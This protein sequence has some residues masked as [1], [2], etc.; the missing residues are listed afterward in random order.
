MADDL[1]TEAY[2][3]KGFQ[4]P[5]VTPL[6]EVKDLAGKV[7]IPDVPRCDACQPTN[8]REVHWRSGVLRL[9]AINELNDE[10]P[11]AV[12]EPASFNAER[13]SFE[14]MW[15]SGAPVVC[16][17]PDSDEQYVLVLPVKRGFLL[18]GDLHDKPILDSH[19]RNSV[20]GILGKVTRV[21]ANWTA[22]TAYAEL[23]FSRRPAVA[24]IVLDIRDGIIKSLS[25][26]S[27]IH[28]LRTSRCPNTGMEIRMALR[29]S[30]REISL[31]QTPRDRD[32][33]FL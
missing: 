22:G 7:Q 5:I 21:W 6:G 4:A 11:I 17:D 8:I 3:Y 9:E 30:P 28:R 13:N 2:H 32:A 31:A 26:G 16:K 20:F 10:F 24:P 18:L 27:H 12:P 23:R 15:S 33:K 14:V 29:W 25:V 19:T 1:I